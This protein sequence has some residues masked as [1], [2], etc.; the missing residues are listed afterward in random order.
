[1]FLINTTADFVIYLLLELYFF[2]W[3]H[4]WYM[5]V[6]GLGVEYELQVTAYTTAIAWWDPSCAAA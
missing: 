2:L 6:P 4:T 1:M 5:E 3:P